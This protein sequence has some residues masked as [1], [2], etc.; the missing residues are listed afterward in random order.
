MLI[1]FIFFEIYKFVL[2]ILTI[3]N[4][5]K[6]FLTTNSFKLKSFFLKR[7]FNSFILLTA[8]TA[9][10]WIVTLNNYYFLSQLYSLLGI[11]VFH[12]LPYTHNVLGNHELYFFDNRH[13][14]ES[15]VNDAVNGSSGSNG[16]RKT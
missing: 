4:F 13:P 10:E 8:I 2:V 6:G 7:G 15:S 16:P 14:T 9:T 5:L 1:S 12:V 11:A 3:I